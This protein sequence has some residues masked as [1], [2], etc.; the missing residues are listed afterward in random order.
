MGTVKTEISGEIAD[1][2]NARYDENGSILVEVKLAGRDWW[3]NYM[4]TANETSAEKQRFYSDLVAGKYGS[5]TPFTVTPEMIR[6]AKD[7]KRGEINAWRDEQEDGNYLFQ[8]NSHRWDYGKAT[9]DRMS[10]SLAM[11]KKGLL[12]EGFAWTDGDNNIVPVTNDSLIALA[13]AIEQAMFE[14]GVQINQR[15]L[16]M[17]AEVEALTTLPA[18]RAYQP[19]WPDDTDTTMSGAG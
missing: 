10:I 4:V 1:M 7:G 16:Q 9:Q 6:A 8:Y 13:G 11:A 17:K 18:I 2:R 14:K 15:Q 19:G 5:V 12:P 3:T